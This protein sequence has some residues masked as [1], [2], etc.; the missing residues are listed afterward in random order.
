MKC[1]WIAGVLSLVMAAVPAAALLEETAFLPV[2]AEDA[3]TD[4]ISLKAPCV[5]A[6]EHYESDGSPS[7]RVQWNTIDGADGYQYEIATDAAYQTVLFSATDLQVTGVRKTLTE[8]GIP[9]YIRV[10][11]YNVTDGV[12]NY[13]DY[14]E[15]LYNAPAA[16]EDPAG[17]NAPEL[18]TT[19]LTSAQSLTLWW[20]AVSNAD[21]Y[22]AELAAN[23][24]FTDAILSTVAPGSGEYAG[25]AYTN[26]QKDVIYY[27]RVRAVDTAD[28]GTVYSP[29]RY[30]TFLIPSGFSILCGD[31]DNSGTVNASDAAKVLIAAAQAGG[32]GGSGLTDMQ[33]MAA[34][35][36]ED[37]TVNASDAAVILMYAAAVGAGQTDV[38]IKDF[39]KTQ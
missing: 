35:V 4:A 25:N 31:V 19:K 8:T 10:R 5:V 36:N 22:E 21:A 39:V 32:G 2:A 33:T 20:S 26:L 15:I 7:V 24:D 38:E 12:T 16:P 23:A 9:Y 11:A 18:Y 27:F 34:D 1:K 28:S 13:S 17:E 6:L 14:G 30:G 3:S 29:Y 37:S